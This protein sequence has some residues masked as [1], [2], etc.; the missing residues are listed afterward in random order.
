VGK[1]TGLPIVCIRPISRTLMIAPGNPPLSRALPAAIVL[2]VMVWV[3]Q[4]LS[5]LAATQPAQP[6]KPQFTVAKETTYIT[7]PIDQ[8]GYIDYAVALNEL[9][10]KGITPDNNANVLLWKTIGPHPEGTTMPP[11]F[12]QWLGIPS[13]PEKGEY[14]VDCFRYLRESLKV[15]V[16]K[17]ADILA[18]QLDRTAQRPWPKAIYPHIAAWLE[19]NDKPLAQ[20]IK[21]TERPHYFSP[22]VP[23]KSDKGST[24]LITTIIPAPQTC[25]ALAAALCTRAMLRLSQ[26]RHDDAWQDLL[27]CHRLGRLVARGG[28]PIEGRIGLAIDSAACEADVVFLASAKLDAKA[29]ANCL[30][31]L[32]KLPPM[33]AVIGLVDIGQRFMFLDAVMLIDRTK[34]I[35]DVVYITGDPGLAKDADALPQKLPADIQWDPALRSGNLWFNRLAA[36]LGVKDAGKRREELTKLE[37]ELDQLRSNL[38]KP[39]AL[40]GPLGGAKSTAETRGRVLGDLLICVLARGTLRLQVAADRNEQTQRNL[41]VACALAQYQ[42]EHGHYPKKL[43]ALATKYLAEIPLDLFTGKQLRYLPSENGYLLYSYGVNGQ[44]DQG[45]TEQDD[46]PGDDLRVLMPLPKLPQR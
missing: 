46:P 10:R 21:A 7:T 31:D 40:S 38:S 2:G 23:G 29:V 36:A 15:D 3:C 25:R 39:G 44:D 43:E 45:R 19:V 34:N 35:E 33:P 9:L 32:Q 12:F 14:F 17:N 28:C 27:A 13:P 20:V 24:G 6:R 22:L 11:K 41:Q 4:S 26:G 8:D 42:R 30:R 37:R 1:K 18:A 16:G 5:D